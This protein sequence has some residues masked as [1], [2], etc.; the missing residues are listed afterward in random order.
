MHIRGQQQ[1]NRNSLRTA[2]VGKFHPYTH[3]LML[4]KCLICHFTLYL[5]FWGLWE[6]EGEGGK[7]ALLLQCFQLLLLFIVLGVGRWGE[8]SG[9]GGLLLVFAC[10]YHFEDWGE[11]K[12]AGAPLLECFSFLLFLSCWGV[13]GR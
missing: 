9:R 4:R 13:R 11:G 7:G 6:R 2:S 10:F 8:G 5:S 3:T 1:D 12:G